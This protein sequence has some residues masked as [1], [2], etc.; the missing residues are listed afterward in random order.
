M[1]ENVIA[2]SGA[3]GVSDRT[4]IT[5]E[6]YKKVLDTS[7]PHKVTNTSFRII[8]GEMRTVRQGKRGFSAL[9]RKMCIESDNI[10]CFPL[11]L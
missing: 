8:N 2:K 1:N 10:H 4:Q 6:H 5:F 7:L 3:K 9:Y 11:K